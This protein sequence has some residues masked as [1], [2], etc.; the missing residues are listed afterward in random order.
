[1]ELKPV[2]IEDHTILAPYFASPAYPLSAYLLP[3]LVAWAECPYFNMRYA[4][5]GDRIWFVADCRD[6]PEKSH[7][8]LPVGG[9]WTPPEELSRMARHFAVPQVWFV[10]QSYITRFTAEISRYFAIT[11]HA[12]YD[13]YLYS[14]V[15]L[16]ELAGGRFGKKRN[17][18]AQF[19]KEYSVNGRVA[20]G[21]ITVGDVEDCLTFLERWLI[22]RHCRTGNNPSLSADDAMLQCE[23]RALELSLCHTEQLGWSSLLVRID[24]VVEG[25]GL[26]APLYPEVAVL[27]FEKAM[28]AHKGLYQFLDRECARKISAEGYNLINKES[29]MGDAGLRQAKRSYLPQHVEKS[30]RLR[31]L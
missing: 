3:S 4:V 12:E 2:K 16:A 10:P 27:S 7:L 24:G 26:W 28:S 20:V 13:D 17:L 31:L 11:E 21:P 18:I 23:K 29:D 1:M 15:D 22:I 5:A 30:M 19:D 6:E 9:Q 25:L 8:L 14:A